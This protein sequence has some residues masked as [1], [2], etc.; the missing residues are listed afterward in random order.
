LASLSERIESLRDRVRGAVA[1]PDEP[2]YEL[3]ET[4][5][6]AVELRPR[7]VIAAVDG[8]DVVQTI[9]FAAT[10]GYRV[11]V[12]CTGH[13]PVALDGDDVLLVHTGHLDE[14]AIDPSARRARIGAGMVW[15]PVIEHAAQ[16]G[17]AALAGSAVSVG[18]TGFLVGAGIGPLVRSHGVS[19][20]R[21]AAFDVVTGAGELLQVTPER[22]PDLFWG[23]RG[24]KATL[25]IVTAVEIELIECAQLYGG[26]V[27]FDG[28]DAAAVM[29]AWARWAT[30]LPEHANTSIAL[31]QLPP[32][33]G[34]PEPLAGRLTLAVRF[35]STEPERAC[36]PLLAPIRA[37]AGP[38]LDGVATIPYTAI[39]SVHA[40][41]ADPMPAKEATALLRELPEP[42]VDTLLTL[43]GPGSGSPQTIVE[44]RLLGGAYARSA[45][46]ASAFCHR[47]AAYNLTMIGVPAVASVEQ[48]A[49]H[50]DGVLHAMAPWAT[51]GMLPNFVASADP[52]VL[53]RRYDEVTRNRLSELGDRYDPAGVLRVGQVIRG[54]H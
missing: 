12:Q 19:S 21:V 11:A 9:R 28:A 40:D 52:D 44:L 24:G 3:R 35:A 2:G 22:H 8:A 42:A 17:L 13:G 48:L 25:G 43:A 15:Q 5:N 26:A 31:L 29:R 46:H 38:L 27:Y 45:E 49:D 32:L 53:G 18:V 1:L 14:L 30:D 54:L 50:A 6:R 10:H 51:G 23:L 4:W 34:V 37:V 36:E 20:D 39:G 47:D 41:P 16:H 33:P 7:A